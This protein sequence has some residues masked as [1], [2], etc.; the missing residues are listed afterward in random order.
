VPWGLIVVLLLS[1]CSGGTSS[2]SD[3][4]ASQAATST[5]QGAASTS[6]SRLRIDGTRFVGADGK[7]FDWRGITAFR[8]GELVAHGREPEAIAFL[9]WAATQKLTVIRVFVMAHHLFQLKPDEGIGSLPRLLELAAARNLYVEIVALADTADVKI[10]F[11]PHVKAVGAVAASHANALVEI[12]NEPWHPTQ[13]T[14][15]HDPAFVKRLASQIPTGVPVALGS[16]ER[17]PGYAEGGYATWHSPRVSGQDGWQHV[18][19]LAEGA[20]L[21]ADW[22]R[23]VVSDEPIGA[24]DADVRGRRDAVAARFAAAGALTRLVGLGA[25]FHYEGG[26][27]ARIPSG[28]ELECLTAWLSGLTLVDDLP[29]GG[30]FVQGD[31]LS[32]VAKVQGV[33]GAFGRLYTN[34][35]WVV[36]VDPGTEASA[37]WGSGW[38]LDGTK[39]IDGA[40][41]FRGRR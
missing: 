7:R 16:A 12:A 32:G 23:P 15:L 22:K 21:I 8:L 26:L 40:V 2:A 10:D 31:D 18:R 27:Q 20:P 28:R 41:L 6:P 24:A 4:G 30:T 1:A 14:R 3:P 11:E 37:E 13:D 35:L 38:R 39:R 34:E 19:E 36:G 29:E 33:R 25:T 5:S 9:D 17:D